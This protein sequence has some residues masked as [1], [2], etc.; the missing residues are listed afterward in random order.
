MVWQASYKKKLV[1]NNASDTSKAHVNKKMAGLTVLLLQVFAVHIRPGGP[2][3]NEL[4]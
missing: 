3:R 4:K 1:E 2:L